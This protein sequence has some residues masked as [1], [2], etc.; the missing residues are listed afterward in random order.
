MGRSIPVCSASSHMMLAL[1]RCSLQ[2]S[3]VGGL[4]DAVC[5]LLCR[6]YALLQ[7]LPIFL[8]QFS[9]GFLCLFC[10]PNMWR[11]RS[12]IGIADW[13]RSTSFLCNICCHFPFSISLAYIPKQTTVSLY[14]QIFVSMLITD[15]VHINRMCWNTEPPCQFYS[16][17]LLLHYMPEYCQ[18]K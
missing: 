11:V 7:Y 12:Y 18:G 5:G 9:V 4:V 14:N 13:K 10:G 2:A 15:D 6:I 16:W 1:A 17:H 3:R 8:S